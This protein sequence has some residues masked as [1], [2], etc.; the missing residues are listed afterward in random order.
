MIVPADRWTAFD[1][2]Y[3]PDPEVAFARLSEPKNY[4]TGPDPARTTV[5][6]AEVPA[7]VGDDV[8]RSDDADLVTL[9]LDGIGRCGLPVPRVVGSQT[10]RLPHVY[11]VLTAGDPDRRLAVLDWADRLPGISVVGRQGLLV[12]DNLHHV[13]DMA[14]SFVDCLDDGRADGGP[15]P[16]R[17]SQARDRFET[18][19]VDD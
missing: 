6:C 1:A 2:H 7:T 12:A 4:R 9:V 18:F 10:V 5:L 13:L 11:P 3:V 8:W 15:D 14:M 19:V 16:I 17:W